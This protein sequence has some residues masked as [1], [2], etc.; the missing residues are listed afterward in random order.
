VRLRARRP[1][2]S[3]PRGLRPG[4]PAGTAR[5]GAGGDFPYELTRNRAM[6]DLAYVLLTV[7]IFVLFGLVVKAVERL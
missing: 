6:A 7:A 4:Y 2:R 5:Y 1:I 3:T